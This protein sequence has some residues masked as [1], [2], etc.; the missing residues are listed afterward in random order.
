MQCKKVSISLPS[1]MMTFVDHYQNYAGCKSRSQVIEEALELLKVRELERAYREASL[2][3]D[4]IWEATTMD[5]LS[6]EMW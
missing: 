1:E 4:P 5:G 2:E 6:D 3:N